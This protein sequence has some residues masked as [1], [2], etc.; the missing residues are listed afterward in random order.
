MTNPDYEP[1]QLAPP[2]GP[3][4]S[5]A[6]PGDGAPRGLSPDSSTKDRVTALLEA[7]LPH[8]ELR[9]ALGISD[10]TLRNWLDESTS[11]RGGVL[12]TLDDLRVTVVAL[13]HAGLAGKRGIQWLLS[14]NL[15]RWTQGSVRSTSCRRTPCYCSQPCRIS[16]S[17]T[18][19][20]GPMPSISTS[21]RPSR[22]QPAR[23]PRRVE[24]A[25]LAAESLRTP[26]PS[27]VEPAASLYAAGRRRL[28]V[29][30]SDAGRTFP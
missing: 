24:R 29:D 26:D 12:R 9:G 27:K 22:E 13:N 20:S 18:R 7:G 14:R 10:A 19:P 5:P 30:V 4:S 3:P 15:G 28:E 2:P 17:P 8:A 21:S 23:A 16:S 1:L 11:P 25:R 6:F